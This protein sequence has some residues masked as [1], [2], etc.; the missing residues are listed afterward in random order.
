MK[1]V[2]ALILPALGALVFI[3]GVVAPANAGLSRVPTTAPDASNSSGEAFEDQVMVE[4][5]AARVGAGVKPI[6]FFDSCVDRLA[7]SWGKH[8]ASTGTFA[9]RDQNDILRKCDQ[10]WAGETLIRGEGMSPKVIVDAWL[11]SP[12][13]RAILLKARASRAGVAVVL[14]AQGRQIGVLNVSDVR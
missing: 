14:D 7:T 12:P 3:V 2:R 9:H 8:I 6:R 5:N 11:A 13:H 4:I 10:S 1:F